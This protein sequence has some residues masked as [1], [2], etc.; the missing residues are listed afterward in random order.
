VHCWQ[1]A[2]CFTTG[3]LEGCTIE[4]AGYADPR[5]RFEHDSLL[6]QWRADNVKVALINA[7]ANSGQIATTSS[8]G[9]QA[10]GS[11]HSDSDGNRRLDV[12]LGK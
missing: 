7:G 11:A 3:P 10:N 6:G 4:L 8:G 9:D 2:D 5:G 1:L 12:L